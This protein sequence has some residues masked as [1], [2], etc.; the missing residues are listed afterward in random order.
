MRYYFLIAGILCILYYLVLV[1]YSRRLRSTF[2]V[3]WVITG[4]VHLIFGCAPFSASVYS[5][6][7]WLCL[8]CWAAILLGREQDH[9]GDVCKM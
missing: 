7:K 5:V 9:P 8:F 1:F 4:G 6:L 2:A 3:F